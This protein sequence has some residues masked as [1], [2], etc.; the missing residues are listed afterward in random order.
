VAQQRPFPRFGFKGKM[1]SRVGTGGV[2]W[3][4]FILVVVA[5]SVGS[6]LATGAARATD[7]V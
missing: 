1:P 6:L 5:C 3:R 7:L 2:V 4:R